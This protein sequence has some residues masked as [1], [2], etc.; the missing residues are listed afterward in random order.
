MEREE[1]KRLPENEAGQ[2]NVGQLLRARLGERNI[3]QA[4]RTFYHEDLGF[5]SLSIV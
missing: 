3:A 5:E 2:R 4:L 1:W